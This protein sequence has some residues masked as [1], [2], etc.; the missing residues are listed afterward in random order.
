MEKDCQGVRCLAFHPTGDYLV[1]GTDHNVLRVYDINTAQC[2]VSA[3][4]T[5]QHTSSVTCAKYASN[6]KMYATGSLDGTIKIWDAVSCRCINTFDKAH[7][8]A[9]V[10]SVSFTRNSKVSEVML[11]SN[12]SIAIHSWSISLLTLRQ[13]YSL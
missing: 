4:P 9:E 1:V 5:Q 11:C 7:D 13:S 12:C 3:V 2:F 6:A 10:C 8:G